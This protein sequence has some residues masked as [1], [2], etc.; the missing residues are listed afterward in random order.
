MGHLELKQQKNSQT[1]E[2]QSRNFNTTLYPNVTNGTVMS[3]EDELIAVNTTTSATTENVTETNDNSKTK[4][5]NETT[6]STGKY[7][8]FRR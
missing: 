6:N 2:C 1:P 4:T 7:Y 5:M 8:S 3:S